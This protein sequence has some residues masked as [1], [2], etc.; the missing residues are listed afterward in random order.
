MEVAD[1]ITEYHAPGITEFVLSGYPHLEEVYWVG[2]G[3]LPELGRRGLWRPPVG[4]EVGTAASVPF[5]Q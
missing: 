4:T 5:A 2:E 1:R 3:V